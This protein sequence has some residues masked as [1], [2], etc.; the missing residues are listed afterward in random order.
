MAKRT[1]RLRATGNAPVPP[2]AGTIAARLGQTVTVR[3]RGVLATGRITL[4]SATGY[5]LV[6]GKAEHFILYT[7]TAAVVAGL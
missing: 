4:V 1:A 5:L 6:N 7:D 2:V 3:T